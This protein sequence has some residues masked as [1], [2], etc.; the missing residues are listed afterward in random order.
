MEATGKNLGT[1]PRRYSGRGPFQGE[2]SCR[3]PEN[4]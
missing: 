2:F 4:D 1:E 3:N